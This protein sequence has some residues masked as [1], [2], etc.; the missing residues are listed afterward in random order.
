MVI[1]IVGLSGSGKSTLGRSIHGLLKARHP[2]TVFIDGDKVREI[3]GNDLGHTM[4]D[5][6]KNAE[7]ICRLCL[8]LDLQELNVVC[9]IMSVFHESQRWNREHFS[10][11][12]EIYLDVS[13]DTLL[14]RDPRGLYAR[15]MRKETVNVVGVDIEYVP[16]YAPDLV[17]NNDRDGVDMDAVAV[18][19]L[20]DLGIDLGPG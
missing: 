4:E 16:P 20:E 18:R 17:I 6:L 5:R 10:S 13:L 1:W 12:K 19:A 3:M 15:A 11:Y 8:Q 14:R 2:G 7:R 9:A